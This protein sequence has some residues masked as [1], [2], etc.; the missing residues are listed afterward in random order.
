MENTTALKSEILCL[1]LSV[2]GSRNNGHIQLILSNRA[3]HSNKKKKK[4]P[5][6]CHGNFILLFIFFKLN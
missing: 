5:T 4:N 2:F 6:Y 3:Q 1:S